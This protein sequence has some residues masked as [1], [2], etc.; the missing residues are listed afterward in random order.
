MAPA[1]STR[2]A[3]KATSPPSAPILPYLTTA[4]D[5]APV[6]LSGPPARKPAS[7]VSSV[8]AT[9][10]PPTF[11]TPDLPMITPLGLIR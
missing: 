8:E 4:A 6:K 10:V 11:T 5:E 2:A 1:L 9:K 7:E 3:I